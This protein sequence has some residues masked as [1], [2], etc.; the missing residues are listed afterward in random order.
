MS[1]TD[2]GAAHVSDPLWTMFAYPREGLPE[3]LFLVCGS[4]VH[5]QFLAAE[6]PVW[7]DEDQF[8]CFG[9]LEAF[10]ATECAYVPRAFRAVLWGT[11]SVDDFEARACMPAH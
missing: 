2:K 9:C 10:L 11:E 1:P 6:L 3:A 5:F 8:S 7:F 4:V